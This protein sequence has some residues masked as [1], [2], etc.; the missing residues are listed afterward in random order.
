M[1]HTWLN[2]AGYVWS[3]LEIQPS[4]VDRQGGQGLCRIMRLQLLVGTRNS[5]I[6]WPTHGAKKQGW[7]LRTRGANSAWVTVKRRDFVLLHRLRR[8]RACHTPSRHGS[9]DCITKHHCGLSTKPCSKKIKRHAKSYAFSTKNRSITQH[10]FVAQAADEHDF[11]SV[12]YEQQRPMYSATPPLQTS[13][14]CRARWGKKPKCEYDSVTG[15]WCLS[16][17]NFSICRR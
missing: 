15:W 7:H 13:K 1:W 3:W 10:P 8:I 4:D 6:G 2:I 9:K 12:F 5:D 17:I 16:T 11:F 14:F